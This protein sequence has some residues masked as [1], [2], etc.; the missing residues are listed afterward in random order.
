MFV[1][2]S[3][4][5]IS[6]AQTQLPVSSHTRIS[7]QNVAWILQA[8]VS[9]PGHFLSIGSLN[10]YTVGIDG[11]DLMVPNYQSC[12]T[13]WHPEIQCNLIDFLE[14]QQCT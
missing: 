14:Y 8:S 2:I 1:A 9:R 6:K 4:F 10:S 11:M 3:N 5:Q 7:S 13:T 12:R